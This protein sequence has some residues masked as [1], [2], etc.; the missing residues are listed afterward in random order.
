MSDF[1]L[2][3]DFIYP[4][5]SIYITTKNINPGVLFGGTWVQTCKSRYMMGA[6]SNVANTD[7]TLGTYAANTN[8]FSAG[9]LL[10]TPNVVLNAGQL[11]KIS[12]SWSIHAQEGGTEFYGKSGYAT[13]TVYSNYRTLMSQTPSSGATSLQNPGFSFGNNEAHNNMPPAEVYYIWKRV[14]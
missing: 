7:D 10:G 5:G 12:G 4:I 6:G 14:A 1:K 8:N 2:N 13:G 11:P 9:D 3:V